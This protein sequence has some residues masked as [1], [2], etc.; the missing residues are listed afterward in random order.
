MKIRPEPGGVDAIIAAI[1]QFPAPESENPAF[2]V[3]GPS[4]LYDS[5]RSILSTN[6][7]GPDTRQETAT[8]ESNRSS[9]YHLNLE[10]PGSPDAL[11]R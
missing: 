3:A 9:L 1:S 6:R 2:D 10:S 8:A 5:A 11:I 4:Q 7:N